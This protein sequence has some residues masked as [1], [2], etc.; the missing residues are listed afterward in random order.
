[1][2]IFIG[3]VAFGMCLHVE[4]EDREKIVASTTIIV[5]GSVIFLSGFM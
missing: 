4:S 5:F 1:M 3:A 2:L